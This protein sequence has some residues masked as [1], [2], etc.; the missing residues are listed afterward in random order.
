MHV[1]RAVRLFKDDIIG[2]L[3][4]LQQHGPRFGIHQF[5]DA[6]GTIEFLSMINKWFTIL[7]VKNTSYHKRS[8]NEDAAHFTSV[9]DSRLVWLE[10]DFLSYLEEWKNSSSDSQQFISKETYDVI[11]LTT[12]SAVLC[13][14][15]L[16]SNGFQY[17]L[18]RKF[19]SDDIEILFSYVRRLSGCNDQTDALSAVQSLHKILVTGIVSKSLSANVEHDDDQD[20]MSG[21][22]FSL[23]SKDQ[24]KL[25]FITIFF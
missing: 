6:T 14:K 23:Q 7:N 10:N 24:G 15:Y 12:K 22:M 25:S 2:V 20:W 9:D 18:T 13:I 17:V 3:K 4:F 16:L 21:N 11:V 1:G 8:R 19:T 5:K